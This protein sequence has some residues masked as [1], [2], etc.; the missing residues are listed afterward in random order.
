MKLATDLMLVRL[1]KEK[2]SNV[3]ETLEQNLIKPVVKCEIVILG[4]ASIFDEE[5]EPSLKVGDVVLM[6]KFDKEFLEYTDDLYIVPQHK[7][8]A[9]LS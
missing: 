2:L 3:I 4:P 8:L 9:L 5:E 7:V 6:N 1:I